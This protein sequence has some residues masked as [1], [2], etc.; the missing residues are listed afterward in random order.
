MRAGVFSRIASFLLDAMPIF[1][2]LSLL[3]SWFV[4]DLIKDQFDN[5]E[6]QS[7]VYQENMDIYYETLDDYDAQL[8]AVEITQQEHEDLTLALMD[9]FNDENRDFVG[10]MFTYYFNIILFYFVSFNFINYFYH[11]ITKGQTIGRKLMKIELAGR[12]HWYTLLLRDLLWKTMFWTFTL[13]AGIAID[14]AL[15]AFTAKKKTLRD[16]LSETQ[17]IVSGT[18]SY[19]F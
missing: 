18:T 7:A 4:G 19:P 14:F 17:I 15:I 16:Y 12:I 11:L 1:L 3:V 13:T 10:V 2:I 5:Y 8:E 9:S 6:E